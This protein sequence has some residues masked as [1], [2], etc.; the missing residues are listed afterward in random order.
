MSGI[1]AS[2]MWELEIEPLQQHQPSFKTDFS[3]LYA[4]ADEEINSNVIQSDDRNTQTVAFK[5]YNCP[6]ELKDYT[7]LYMVKCKVEPSVGSE[8]CRTRSMCHLQLS[9]TR[10]QPR[11]ADNESDAVMYEVLADQTMWAVCGRTA[12]MC[13]C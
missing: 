2:F 10:C 7:T 9:V 6:F 11:M 13:C 1:T 12:G 8:F 4:P 5:Q 3:I